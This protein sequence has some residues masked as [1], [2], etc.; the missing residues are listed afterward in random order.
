MNSSRNGIFIIGPAT[1]HDLRWSALAH[2]RPELAIT[3]VPESESMAV[4]L[5][6]LLAQSQIAS[7][8][9]IFPEVW[10]SPV[11]EDSIAHVCNELDR[12]CH[13]NWAMVS[14]R[15]V[16]WDG[17]HTYQYVRQP[18]RNPHSSLSVK[19]VISCGGSVYVLNLV[20]LRNARVVIP[21]VEDYFDFFIALGVSALQV[22]LPIFA[23]RRLMVSYFPENKINH[24][25]SLRHSEQLKRFLSSQIIGHNFLSTEG[26]I[27]LE[28]H[29]DF[30][31]LRL[32]K[33]SD[34][35]QDL[36]S[37]YERALQR[38]RMRKIKID[39]AIRSCLDRD[40]LLE[41]AVRSCVCAAIEGESDLEV[42]IRIISNSSIDEAQRV[43]KL[44]S[45]VFPKQ[46]ISVETFTLRANRFS[47]T[48]LLLQAVETSPA[49]Y[50]WFIDDDDF[51]FPGGARA[52]ARTIF[53][54]ADVAIFGDS[55]TYEERW[56]FNAML[57]RQTL[58][59][60]E[61]R[62]R[63]SSSGVLKSFHGENHIPICGMVLPVALLQQQ[64]KNVAA[65]GDYL[66]D[67]FILLRLLVAPK[68]EIEILPHFI[69]GISLR[70]SENTVRSRDRSPWNQS[71]ASF[72][73]EIL[74]SDEPVNPLL[75]QL[76]A[77]AETL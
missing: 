36:I 21:R 6:G 77:V 15:G 57:G 30:S 5:T 41:R 17:Q 26:S 65:H 52:L 59:H 51:V 1:S 31:Y 20:A 70:G 38:V 8:T 71:Y 44:M 75:W 29:S 42:N 35:R 45:E 22:G 63:L 16:R 19:P 27:N 39:I 33:S 37:L 60:F 48:D 10:I 69:A 47:R 18:P 32:P 56:R 74:A 3:R 28:G 25:D 54:P 55:Q 11:F 14:N 50:I 13:S 73:H 34:Q 64:L 23:D 4:L 7:A 43:S 40:H 76:G 2:A 61:P 9:F 12:L 67:Y 68:L 62:N 72:L 58:A 49:D 24:D 66:E 53:N 46:N